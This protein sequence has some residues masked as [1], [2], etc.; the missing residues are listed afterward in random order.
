MGTDTLYL[1]GGNVL[2]VER[3]EQ[4]ITGETTKPDKTWTYTDSAGHL[5][6]YAE[7]TEDTDPYPTL[8]WLESEPYY[9]DTCG[10]D[11]ADR[12]R[13]CKACGEAVEPRTYRVTE[14]VPIL[15][16]IAYFYNDTL[17]NRD[18]FNRI[19]TRERARALE[20]VTGVR[21]QESAELWDDA[22]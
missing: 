21:T 6:E 16:S 11:H 3:D 15:R 7:D 8:E 2:R 19:L 12:W 4:W 9:C 20:Q 1:S 18:E 13:A 10:D 22:T 17:I 14:T 5:H